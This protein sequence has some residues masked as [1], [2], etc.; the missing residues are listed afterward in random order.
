LLTPE[1][2]DMQGRRLSLAHLAT[3]TAPCKMSDDAKFILG[4][5]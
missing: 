2:A 1:L 3:N 4:F 5:G